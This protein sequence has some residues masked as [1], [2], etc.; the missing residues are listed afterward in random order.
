MFD[1]SKSKI[2]MDVVHGYIQI[3]TVFV[4]H[5]IDSELFQRLRNIDQTGMRILY[6]NARHDRFSHSLGVF[7]LGQKAVNALLDNFSNDENVVHWNIRSDNSHEIFWAKNKV[8]FLIACLLHDIG[9]APFSH[10]LESNIL[11]N[12]NSEL[13]K[14]SI[15]DNINHYE[16][17]SA[18]KLN[19]G[20]IDASPHEIVGANLIFEKFCEPVKHILLDL[21]RD[22]Y[23]SPSGGI[24]YAEHFK[25]A[26]PIDD[27]ELY[28]DISFVVRMVLGLKYDN[29]TPEKQIRNC[30][31][32]LLNSGNFDVDKLDYI[33]RDTKM[34][35]ISNINIDVERL[36]AS[37]SIVT[38]TKY[39]NYSFSSIKDYSNKMLYIQKLK[40]NDNKISIEGE[41]YGTIKLNAKTHVHI[42]HGSTFLSM[43]APEQASEETKNNLKVYLEKHTSFKPSTQV[44]KD[45]MEYRSS[46]NPSDSIF[47]AENTN[48]PIM[49]SVENAE[50]DHENGFIFTVEEKSIFYL[51]LK[52]SCSIDIEGTIE[53]ITPLRVKGM[54]SGKLTELIVI[55]DALTESVPTGEKYNVFS[56]GFKKQAINIIANVLD[57]RDYLYRWIYAHHKVIYYAN[58]LI[59]VITKAILPTEEVSNFPSWPLNYNNINRLDDAYIY[60]AIRSVYQYGKMLDCDTKKLIEE[61]LNRKYKKSLYKSL[62]EYDMVFAE[63]SL[64]DKRLIRGKLDRMTRKENS[65]ENESL[66]L[67]GGFFDENHLAQLK[68]VADEAGYDIKA[69]KDLLWVD[70]SYKHKK[71]DSRQTY[72]IFPQE[73]TILGN[74]D[75]FNTQLE[76]LDKGTQ[77]YFY[78][79]Y[80]TEDS[81]DINDIN[82]ISES[83]RYSLI[84]FFN[85]ELKEPSLPVNVAE[86]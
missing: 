84:E 71:L 59:P 68:N 37:I 23:P 2:F 20:C 57:A 19:Y 42:K 50:V 12:S 1:F 33:I 36:I 27:S 48:V 10:S 61:F 7:Y 62:A 58:F 18:N 63:F 69:L 74:L 29:F 13:L 6:P 22:K 76:A 15:I 66:Q 32:E 53:N 3:P 11:T 65:I 8:L 80:S 54:C 14:N 75:L 31:I 25:P 46:K 83:L 41:V 64:D 5:I 81:K 9:H 67:L 72:V 4:E 60:T 16:N 56:V 45:K 24:I 51:E 40:L 85:R 21:K 78:I 77:H 43:K 79:Y 55:S 28:E 70:A 35:G 52:G 82:D 38:K 86:L 26:P 39:L 17:D 34:S 30:F 47:L 44:I 49:L 73:I